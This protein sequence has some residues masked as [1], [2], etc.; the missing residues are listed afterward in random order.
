MRHFSERWLGMSPNKEADQDFNPDRRAALKKIVGLGAA[1][2]TGELAKPLEAF[3]QIETGEIK[4]ENGLN[5][6]S[7]EAQNKL[8]D[9]DRIFRAVGLDKAKTPV[10]VGTSND[11]WRGFDQV[12]KDI[13][14]IGE[15]ATGSITAAFAFSANEILDQFPDMAKKIALKPDYV[16]IILNIDNFDPKHAARYVVHESFH[17]KHFSKRIKDFPEDRNGYTRDKNVPKEVNRYLEELITNNDTLDFLYEQAEHSEKSVLTQEEK[18]ELSNLIQ[19][20]KEYF[21]HNYL[22]Y[23]MHKYSREEYPFF[24]APHG[25]EP[26]KTAELD[27][28]DNRVE[29]MYIKHGIIE[30]LKN[31]KYE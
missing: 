18:D 9:L 30:I 4:V 11:Y 19:R 8:K 29:E 13:I 23:Y 20:E 21:F 15:K 5:Y 6:A 27:E 25:E 2:L 24:S 3:S 22:R 31:Q 1:A 16:Y 10:I 17:A 7:I 12:Q 26:D 28:L 14:D